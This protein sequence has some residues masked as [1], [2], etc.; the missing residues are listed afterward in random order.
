MTPPPSPSPAMNRAALATAAGR[1]NRKEI[2]MSL[3]LTQGCED[4]T[5]AQSGFIG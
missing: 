1:H 2:A 5:V 4:P 3:T